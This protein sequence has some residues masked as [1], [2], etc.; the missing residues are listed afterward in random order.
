MRLTHA[1]E[2]SAV[3]THH[4]YRGRGHAAIA[5]SAAVHAVLTDGALPFLHVRDG[6]ASAIHL[7]ERLGFVIRTTFPIGMYQ[8]PAPSVEN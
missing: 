2:I 4:D 5:T 7:Y 6:N 1:V 3:C 8:P